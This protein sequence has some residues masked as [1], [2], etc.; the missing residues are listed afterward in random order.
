MT[1][2]I[3]KL[4]DAARGYE[5]LFMEGQRRQDNRWRL[6][7]RTEKA[8]GKSVTQQWMGPAGTVTEWEGER[9]L[10][11]FKGYN[12]TLENKK[13][14]NAVQ[15]DVDDLEDDNM[16]HYGP[17]IGGLP[18]QF[19]LHK[20]K[21]AFELMSNGFTATS[22]LAYDGQLFFDSD[23]VDHEE[24]AQTNVSDVVFST[25]GLDTGIEAMSMVTNSKGDFLHMK[26][27]HLFAPMALRAK[28]KKTLG[29]AFIVEQTDNGQD[30]AAIENY[31]K[32]EVTPIVLPWL[33]L[34][35]TTAWYLFDLSKPIKPLRY[36]ERVPV[37]FQR[38][39]GMDSMNVFMHDKLYFGGRARYN[40]GYGHWQTG[41]GSTG[42]A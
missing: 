33:D 15:V 27:T 38:P 25:T 40:L 20:L 39:N 13:W 19:E 30:A 37:T 42:L 22:G 10:E 3:A 8:T 18:E 14:Q 28:V 21:L 32:D 16:G 2:D 29:N 23:H 31:N 6:L 41:W 26:P 4:R 12:F 35:S 9:P 11:Q 36:Q 7:A 5:A 1:L 17:A 24:D 34:Y